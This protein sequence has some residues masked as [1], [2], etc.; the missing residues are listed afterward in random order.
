MQLYICPITYT[1]QINIIHS[2]P[3]ETSTEKITKLGVCIAPGEVGF[4]EAQRWCPRSTATGVQVGWRFWGNGRKAFGA[5]YGGFRSR[6]DV[7]VWLGTSRRCLQAYLYNSERR[8]GGGMFRLAVSCS[9]SRGKVYV[10]CWYYLFARDK[11][12]QLV[13]T[14]LFNEYTF[15]FARWFALYLF[16]W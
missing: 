7:D 12:K 15:M 10:D 1:S 9:W 14:M 11:K 5:G 6:L 2:K 3:P 13:D 4:G 16:C 8:F